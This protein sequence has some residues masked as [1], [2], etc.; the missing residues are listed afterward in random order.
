M[1]GNRQAAPAYGIWVALTYKDGVLL[2]RR[3][4][5]TQLY[6]CFYF[7]IQ[8]GKI[9]TEILASLP[10]PLINGCAVLVNQTIY[11][12]GGIETP[13]GLTQNNF[14]SLDLSS[15]E[16]KWKILDPVPGQT[17]MLALRVPRKEYLYFWW[18]TSF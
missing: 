12:A 5:S 2:L 14:W 11:I 8:V 3:R 6:R 15:H 9:E 18:R 17:R 13:A 1:E 7:T 4:P 10:A 16:N